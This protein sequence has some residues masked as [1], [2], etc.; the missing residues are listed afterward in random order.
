MEYVITWSVYD[1]KIKLMQSI[2]IFC[3]DK[4]SLIVYEKTSLE[5]V[6]KIE[7]DTMSYIDKIQIYA[8]NER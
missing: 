4:V 5:K 2:Y 7:I 1:D 8:R 3:K 6:K